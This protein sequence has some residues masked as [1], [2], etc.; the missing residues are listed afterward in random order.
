MRARI[1]KQVLL[2]VLLLFILVT[3]SNAQLKPNN[4]LQHDIDSLRKVVRNEL[5]PAARVDS[6]IYL[7]S[8]YFDLSRTDSIQYCLQQGF[9]IIAQTPY[10]SGEYFLLSYQTELLDKNALYDEALDYAQKSLRLAKSITDREL[11]GDSYTLLGLVYNDSGQPL[12]AIQYLRHSLS[13]IPSYTHQK[14]PVSQRHHALL[15]LGQCYLKLKQHNTAIHWLNQSLQEATTQQDYRIMSIAHWLLGQCYDSQ[16]HF[17]LAGQQYELGYKYANS[18]HDWDAIILFFPHLFYH[19][20]RHN[21]PKKASDFLEIGR[22]LAEQTPDRIAALPRKNFYV[23]LVSIYR[24]LKDYPKAVRA[25]QTV[26]EITEE[27]NKK[28][29]AQRLAL[30]NKFNQQ[31]SQ[32]LLLDR[33]RKM[34]LIILQKNRLLNVALSLSLLLLAA[35]FVIIYYNS[36][37]R[38]RLDR[39]RQQRELAELEQKREVSTLKAVIVGEERERNRLANEL[40][41]GVGGL[42]ISARYSLE[43]QIRM[44]PIQFGSEPLILV[45]NAYEEIRRIAHNLM[46]HTLQHV[47]LAAALEQYCESIVQST[48]LQLTLQIYGVAERLE[49]SLELWLYRIVQE[50][51]SNILKHAKATTALIQLSNNNGLVH[52]TVEDNGQGFVVTE[53]LQRDGF[54]LR[55]LADRAYYLNGTVLIESEPGAGTSIFIELPTQSLL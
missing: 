31:E 52:L 32:L 40:H 34:Q 19:Y 16:R 47:G 48:E 41:N 43:R 28:A 14:H 30:L 54:G 15:N 29:S 25:Q 11:I 10:R 38:R 42:L 33:E 2:N 39:L 4:S 24:L 3:G 12:K 46:P 27:I 6:W 7:A 45:D 51:V 55:Q 44:T 49:S 20:Y 22:Q 17:E 21:Q 53:V 26:L 37:Q 36:Q 8:C 1:N 9:Q 35:I 18:I 23:E 13:L 50:L 5:T